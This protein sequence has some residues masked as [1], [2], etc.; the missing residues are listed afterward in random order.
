MARLFLTGGSGLLGHRVA[1]IF[2]QGGWEVIAPTHAELDLIDGDTVDAA[3]STAAP[4]LIIN[5]AA[6]RK[7]DLCEADTPEVRALNIHLPER[8]AR[9][10]IPLVHI[11]TDYVFNGANAPYAP[12]AR[13]C[14]VNTYGRQ[15]ALAEQAVE[16]YDHVLILRLPI[17]Y[18]PTKDWRTS[19]V[20]VL[21]ANLRA[22]QGA[23]V[24]MDDIA[25]RYPTLTDDIARQLLALAPHV[26]KPLHGIWHYS[27]DEPMTKFQ[28]A[29]V[30]APMVGCAMTQCIPDTRPPTVPRPYDCH[31]STHTL[32]QSGHYVRPTPFREAIASIIRNS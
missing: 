21:A 14:P 25:I 19:A 27:G 29:Q 28:M 7:P 9:R 6:Q 4:D 23:P 10:G 18:G 2:R 3:L 17:L 15:K 11:S 5:C 13:R 26:G 8:L 20:T 24:L 31:L 1:K 32:Q 22:A 16:S 12:D 30:M